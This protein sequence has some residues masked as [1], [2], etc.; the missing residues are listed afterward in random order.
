M[1]RLALLV[2][3]S[4]SLT[5]FADEPVDGTARPESAVNRMEVRLGA[6]A[7]AGRMDLMGAAHDGLA[8]SIDL[9]ALAWLGPHVGVGFHIGD[10]F[11]APLAP[12]MM[13]GLTVDRELPWIVEPEVAVRTVALHRGPVTAGLMATA[14]AGIAQARTT[15]LCGKRCSKTL[16]RSIE[17][18][19]SGQLLAFAHVGRGALT[20]GPRVTADTAGDAAIDLEATLG[21]AW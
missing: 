7:G 10:L 11:L 5:A 16:E 19:A 21:V 15:G 14:S 8:I 9:D 20:I 1:L 2:L 17:T 6:G 18:A 3:V 4:T 12:V 13:N